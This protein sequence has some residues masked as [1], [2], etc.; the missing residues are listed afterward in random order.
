MTSIGLIETLDHDKTFE[1]DCLRYSNMY[2]PVMNYVRHIIFFGSIGAAF[3]ITKIQIGGT[4][5]AL[6]LYFT[7]LFNE[8]PHK[9]RRNN[10][11]NFL[12]NFIT[13]LLICCK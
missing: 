1:F 8:A 7:I 12:S 6:F 5:V 9:D 11:T 2:Y 4:I 3:D 13:I 10:V